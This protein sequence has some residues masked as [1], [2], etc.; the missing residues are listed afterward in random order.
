MGRILAVT[1]RGEWVERYRQRFSDRDYDLRLVANSESAIA[2]SNAGL[3]DC[4]LVDGVAGSI[5]EFVNAWNLQFPTSTIPVL[6]M[7]DPRHPPAEGSLCEHLT[8]F[9]YPELGFDS[10][11]AAVATAVEAHWLKHRLVEMG[12]LALLGEMMAGVLHELKNPI[13]NMLGGL[14]RISQR[15][16]ADPSAARWAEII[17]RNG[18]LLRESVGS[19]LAGFRSQMPPQPVNVHDTL[20]KAAHY[21]LKGDISI[22]DIS[23]VKEHTAVHAVVHASPGPLLHLFLNLLVNA[24]Q[25]IGANPGTITVRTTNDI[26]LLRVEVHD[27]GPGIDPSMI[28]KLFQRFQTTKKTGSGIGLVLVKSVAEQIGGR[29][30][31]ENSPIGGAI[32]RVELPLPA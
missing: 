26:G 3:P 1:A 25:A 23:L 18:E 10:L 6:A 24:R 27:S 16:D 32:F 14:D 17:R 20:D 15:M 2:H 5:P 21:A 12:K 4:V 29:V 11:F 30:A 13:N 22:R 8:G 19:L 28:G 31:A 9:V 7:M